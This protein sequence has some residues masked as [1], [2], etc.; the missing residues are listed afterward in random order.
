MALQQQNLFAVVSVP[1]AYR[2]ITA[3]RD[4]TLAIRAPGDAV[5]C[6]GMAVERQNLFPAGHIPNSDGMVPTSRSEPPCVGTE[7]DRGNAVDMAEQR[8]F[9]VIIQQIVEEFAS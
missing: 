5:R 2:S 7:R 6:P 1:D 9:A 8:A 4:D 3:A